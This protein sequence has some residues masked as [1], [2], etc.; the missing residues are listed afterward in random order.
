M[1][2]YTHLSVRPAVSASM[3]CFT[4]IL[5]NVCW[6]YD[7]DCDILLHPLIVINLKIGSPQKACIAWGK[8]QF[9]FFRSTCIKHQSSKLDKFKERK[10]FSGSKEPDKYNNRPNGSL[11]SLFCK[12]KH[13]K[14]KFS[15]IIMIAIQVN[16]NKSLIKFIQNLV[17]LKSYRSFQI[18]FFLLNTYLSLVTDKL[19]FGVVVSM[20]AISKS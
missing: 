6:T 5:F 14:E 9:R 17:T 18:Q 12:F 1:N 11:C 7:I 13:V 3:H 19:L 16:A 20:H 4:C 2:Y 8:Q 15:Q 10:R